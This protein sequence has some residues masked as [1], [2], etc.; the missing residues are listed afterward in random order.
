M[1]L[2][3]D[4]ARRFARE[5]KGCEDLWHLAE[6]LFRRNESRRALH[7]GRVSTAAVLALHTKAKKSFKALNVLAREGYGEDAMVLARSL[8]NLCIDLGYICRADSDAR[9]SQWI[10]RGRV[11]RRDLGARFGL[12]APGDS[13]I[14]WGRMEAL[15]REWARVRIADRADL[16]DLGTFYATSYAHGCVFDHSDAWGALAYLEIAG[17]EVLAYPDPSA[18]NVDLA[19]LSGA[20]AF[21]QV[22]E[23]AGQYWEFDFAGADAEMK[24]IVTEAFEALPPSAPK[25]SGP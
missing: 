4:I 8:T 21:G 9:A 23:T 10:A 13:S 24:R 2:Q 7:S 18:K 16:A 14:D 17:E 5:L 6:D 19:L 15:A 22:V 25:E 3:A 11:S 12:T 1:T 20:F